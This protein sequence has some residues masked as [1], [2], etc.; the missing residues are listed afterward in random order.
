MAGSHTNV[1]AN[2]YDPYSITGFSELISLVQ[3]KLVFVKISAPYQN[4]KSAP[5]YEDTRVI[6]QTIM[7]NGPD[8]VVFGSDWPHIASK[9][10]N[11][12]AGGRLNPQD[13][14]IIDDAGLIKQ[15]VEWAGSAEQ[16]WCCL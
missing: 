15:T 7:V 10:G 11:G 4:S 14:R 5:L 8:M 13:F 6:G 9:E 12:A 1:T 16:V 3:R 2:T